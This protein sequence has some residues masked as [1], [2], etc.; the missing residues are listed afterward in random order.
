MRVCSSCV[1]WGHFG[2][3]GKQPGH[4]LGVQ[5][6]IMTAADRFWA[7]VDKS[8][9]CWVWCAGLT[10]DGYGRFRVSWKPDVRKLAHVFAYELL[11]GPVLKGKQLDHQCH[12][13]A[14][15]NP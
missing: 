15:V 14:C 1:S 7:K 10:D 12:N 4:R 13:R 11:V 9:D 3:H 2:A 8:G 6:E 5:E